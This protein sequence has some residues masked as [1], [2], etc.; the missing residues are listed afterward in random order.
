MKEDKRGKK[1]K[2]GFE[3]EQDG[4]VGGRKVL[5]GPT[6]DGECSSSREKA[7]DSERRDEANGEGEVKVA[8]ERQGYGH[9]ECCK[10]NLEG[11]ELGYGYAAGGVGDRK[12][13]SGK[14]Q[15]AGE[16]EQVA[17][18]DSGEDILELGSGGGGEQKQAAKGE[19]R[20]ECCVPAGGMRSAGPESGNDGQEGD[21]DDDQPGDEGGLGGGG[22]G[23]A[24]G[25][26]LV[27]GG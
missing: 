3:G 6:L 12:Q 18:A 24:C 22:A 15:S 14:G 27:A 16:G 2:D 25:L 23:E 20:T 1:G 4:C 5:L 8:S 11:G 9:D 10:T 13:M 17:D 26:E 7:G 21:K 19:Q